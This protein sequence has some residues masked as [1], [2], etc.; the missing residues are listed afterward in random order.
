M[1]AT[2]DPKALISDSIKNPK[3]TVD[4]ES[5]LAGLDVDVLGFCGI[6]GNVM[7]LY[8]IFKDAFEGDGEYI[9]TYSNFLYHYNQ[10]KARK[11][12]HKRNLAIT[13]PIKAKPRS[14]TTVMLTPELE[15]REI[16]A[17][18]KVIL[19]QPKKKV[20]VKSVSTGVL[21]LEERARIEEERKQKIKG[22][23]LNAD[24]EEAKTQQVTFADEEEN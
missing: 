5:V 22:A 2:T 11:E 6:R 7:R 10:F 19:A 3:K 14:K 21:S 9:G 17:N 24:E 1:S 20:T 8:K 18:G 12:R 23:I 13:K 16:P 4:I 15:Q